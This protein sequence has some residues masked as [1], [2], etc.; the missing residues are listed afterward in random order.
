MSSVGLSDGA[1]D[2]RERAMTRLANRSVSQVAG[3]QPWGSFDADQSG[4]EEFC[5]F[6]RMKGWE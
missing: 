5:V 1:L 4:L 2:R 6:W 3:V